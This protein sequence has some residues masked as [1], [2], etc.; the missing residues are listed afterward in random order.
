MIEEYITESVGECERI[1]E[2]L[3]N[4]Y[5]LQSDAPCGSLKIYRKSFKVESKNL[6]IYK[7]N[8]FCWLMNFSII[9]AYNSC[10]LLLLRSIQL[11]YFPALGNPLGNRKNMKIIQD[12]IKGSV[13]NA[14]TTN[15]RY[16]IEF[17]KVKSEEFSAFVSQIVRVDLKTNWSGFFE[18]ISILRNVIAHHGTIVN[19]DTLN[20]IKMNAKDVFERHFSLIADKAG[21]KLLHPKFGESFSNFLNLINDFSLNTAKFIFNENDL[22]FLDLN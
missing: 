19:I 13:E 16:I 22:S 8:F 11:A 12:R 10:E 14:D 1:F 17:L 21:F 3:F 15:N 20:Q 18:M 4:V 9:K 7:M 6:Q 5:D 2:S